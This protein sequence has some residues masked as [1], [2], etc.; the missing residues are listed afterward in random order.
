MH[1]ILSAFFGPIFAKELVEMSR[2]WQQYVS[3]IVYGLAL[4]ILLLFMGLEHP[5]L[6]WGSQLDIRAMSR[7]ANDIFL[8]VSILQYAAV[9]LFVPVFVCSVIAGERE[10]RTLELLFTTHL[11]NRQIVLSKLVSRMFVVTLLIL[12]ALPV[13]S[14][15]TLFGGVDPRAVM[16]NT[17][18]TLLALLFVG[19]VSIYMSATTK[20]P[21]GALVRTYGWLLV[22]L[23]AVPLLT[24]LI[25]ESTMRGRM[26]PAPVAL[27]YLQL[28]FGLMHPVFVFAIGLE[29]RL[30]DSLAA[31]AG[32][33][34]F[35][36]FCYVLPTLIS[37]FLLWRASRRLRSEPKTLRQRLAW[38]G[39]SPDGRRVRSRPRP[40]IWRDVA[41]PLWQRARLVRVYDREGYVGWIQWLGWLAAIAFFILMM[42]TEPRAMR[43]EDGS[44][45]FL[46]PTYLGLAVLTML[47]AS[48]SIVGDRRRGFFEQVLVTPVTAREIVDGTMLAVWQHLRPVFLLALILGITFTLTGASRWEGVLVCL[49]S[50][51]LFCVLLA[52]VGVGCSLAARTYVGALVPTYLYGVVLNMGLAMMIGGLEEASGP[53]IW[54]IAAS[55]MIIS[56]LAVRR[57][58]NPVLVGLFFMSFYLVIGSIATFW[59]WDPSSRREEFPIALMHPVYL[60]I[61]PLDGRPAN[62]FD[63]YLPWYA[64]YAFFWSGLI[65]NILLVRWWLIR[66]FDRLTGRGL[67]RP[68][69]RQ[70]VAQRVEQKVLAVAE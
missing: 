41:N 61:R 60:A 19:S 31:A 30:F 10:E 35:Y 55:L 3:R 26:V 52:A 44:F 64:V 32:T 24:V 63:G 5:R 36:P 1:E 49:I 28:G 6:W 38:L 13:F 25:V 39:Q 17:A 65:I 48:S 67:R 45:A 62:W 57:W 4:L 40:R 22:W 21:L 47:V 69:A 70:A 43:D 11:T 23:V 53:A 59:T 20:S 14:L 50:A 51:M 8:A 16:M 66:N 42:A 29:P 46:V 54:I 12:S 27:A 58:T 34:W 33:P 2:R 37:L 68:T 9:Y 18:A 15:I 56:A 7:L